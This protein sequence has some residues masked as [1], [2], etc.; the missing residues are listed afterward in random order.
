M[1]V[2]PIFDALP[3]TNRIRE[4]RD[5]EGSDS[6]GQGRNPSS[7]GSPN[8][9]NSNGKSKNPFTEIDGDLVDKAVDEFQTDAQTQAHGLHAN[10]SGKGPGLKVTLTDVSG[11]VVR[12]FTGE[13]FLRLRD[14]VSKEGRTRGKILDQKL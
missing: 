2:L 12:Q 7:D 1:K 9:P 14:A 5:G 10:V 8:D 4:K 11:S 13:E 6:R 3:F